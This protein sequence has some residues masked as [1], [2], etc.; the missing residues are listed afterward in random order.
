MGRIFF[1]KFI[2]FTRYFSREFCSTCIWPHIWKCKRVQLNWYAIKHAEK[3]KRWKQG[4]LRTQKVLLIVINSSIALC[5]NV[6]F[7]M[8]CNSF[9]LALPYFGRTDHN[10]KDFEIFKQN[11]FCKNKFLAF[12][13]LCLNYFSSE[14]DLGLINV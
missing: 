4:V 11:P 13:N 9:I 14:S 7:V 10:K 8:R 1:T 6:C 5:V 2:H 12:L 3:L